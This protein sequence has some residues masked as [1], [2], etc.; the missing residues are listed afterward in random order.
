LGTG[1]QRDI[2]S[3]LIKVAII[4]G[5][6][7][8]TFTFAFGL[9][10]YESPSMSPAVHSGDL[11]MFSRFDRNYF[12]QDLIVVTFQGETQIRRVVAVAGDTVDFADGTLLL[13]GV[14]QTE[15]RITTETFRYVSEIDFPLTVPNGYV[16]VLADH[17]EYA[18]DSRT[19]GAVPIDDTQGKV[20]NIL[21]SR[22]F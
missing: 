11:I 13:D 3:L 10:R 2:L 12:A 18:T 17:R 14:P 9:V 15:E 16:F 19:Y 1:L 7:V 8:A 22:L 21:R 6:V 20:V 4:V 5:I